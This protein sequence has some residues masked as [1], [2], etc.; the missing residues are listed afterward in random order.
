MTGSSALPA[1][2]ARSTGAAARRVLVGAA[3]AAG[4]LRAFAQMIYS[5]ALVSMSSDLH[6]SPAGIGLTISVYGL[7]VAVCQI[8]FGPLV[9]RFS[10][11]WIL[12]AGMLLF[13]AGSWWGQAAAG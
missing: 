12:G 10:S 4:F 6:T 9:D 1:G 5:G 11:K 7:S 8:I 3:L 13:T 2:H